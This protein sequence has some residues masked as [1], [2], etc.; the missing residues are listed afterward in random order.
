MSRVIIYIDCYGDSYI[1]VEADEFHEDEGFIKAYK[2]SELVAMV[3]A[4]EVKAVW[5]SEREKSNVQ[6]S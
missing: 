6:K 1:N 4:S 2:R 3:R 5:R